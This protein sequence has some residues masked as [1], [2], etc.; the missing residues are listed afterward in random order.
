MLA[1]V[2]SHVHVGLEIIPLV[3]ARGEISRAGIS[4]GSLDARD[5][6]PGGQIFWP[7]GVPMTAVVRGHVHQAVVRP[8][9]DDAVID[10]RHI[11]GADARIDL[12][13]GDIR[14]DRAAG[15]AFSALVVAREVRADLGPGRTVIQTAQ[16]VLRADQEFLR[17]AGRKQYRVVN[18]AEAVL[19]FRGSR[20]VAVDGRG[21]YALHHAGAPVIAIHNRVVAARVRDPGRTGLRHHPTAFAAAHVFPGGGRNA[22]RRHGAGTFGR[23]LVLLR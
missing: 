8:G 12:G 7:H 18:P 19:Q 5:R 22:A 13:A 10:G 21:R 17:I 20:A 1:V 9:P 11:H 14:A 15:A 16:Y 23:T 6:G 4:V 3:A 2:G